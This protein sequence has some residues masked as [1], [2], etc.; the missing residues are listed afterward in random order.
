MA[1]YIIGLIE[2]ETYRLPVYFSVIYLRPDAGRRDTGY[3]E[4]NIADHQVFIK[5]KV[6]PSH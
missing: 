4:Q 3:Y 6:F 1:G 5:Y 2:T